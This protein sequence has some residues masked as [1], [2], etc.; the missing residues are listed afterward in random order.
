MASIALALVL[1]LTCAARAEPPQFTAEGSD[2]VFG[3]GARHIAMGGTGTATAD[4]V[5]AL[6]YN[7]ANLARIDRP[8]ATFDRQIDAR[9]RPY[10]LIGFA[11]PLDFSQSLGLRATLALG[12]YPRIHAHS[13]GAFGPDDFESI[14]LRF[15]LPGLKGTYSGVIDSKTL[16]NRLAL[17]V[18]PEATPRLS[19]GGNVDYIDCRTGTCGV[20]AGTIYS[21]HATAVAYG[22][23]ISYRPTDRLT[24]GANYSDLSKGMD[25]TTQVTDDEG[26]HLEHGRTTLPRRLGLE[27]AW[28]ARDNLL[29]ALGAQSYRGTYGD[30]DLVIDTLH[31]GAEWH[32]DGAWVVRAGT[33]S[34]L[35]IESSRFEAPPLLARA[36]PTLGLGWARG[37]LSADLAVFA[38][39]VDSM[40]ARRPVI[41]E[42]LSLTFRF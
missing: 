36:A 19:F 16:V 8:L 17:G 21:V 40:H 25:I 11:L 22:L 38:H 15:L 9:L 42:E 26:S 20:S 14:F 23:S 35:V 2:S 31:L 18:A 3:L 39:P 10:S 33:W 32:P 30:Y 24:L 4:D 41:S 28:T 13:N 1:T 37:A 5:H 29:L 27:A 34:P 7:P 12:R 6:Y